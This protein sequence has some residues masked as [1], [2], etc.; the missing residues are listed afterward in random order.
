MT[1]KVLHFATRKPP[2]IGP[3]TARLD[4]PQVRS[5]GAS[6]PLLSATLTLSLNRV[7]PGQRAALTRLLQGGRPV[8]V[9]LTPDLGANPDPAKSNGEGPNRPAPGG[10]LPR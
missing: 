8:T 5:G 6:G 1:G 7:P 2:A 9:T 3:L 10:G 4:H